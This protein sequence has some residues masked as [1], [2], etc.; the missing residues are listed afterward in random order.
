MIVRH[1]ATKTT[2]LQVPATLDDVVYIEVRAY[3][4]LHLYVQYRQLIVQVYG[5]AS[6]DT[7]E[8]Q[9][10]QKRREARL[11]ERQQEVPLPGKWDDNPDRSLLEM[12]GVSAFAHA[13]H[14][15]EVVQ[16]DDEKP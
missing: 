10:Q 16:R 2:L 15:R 9:R 5:C 8:A 12:A 11:R 3:V 7:L 4:H 13:D 1:D 14:M 6:D